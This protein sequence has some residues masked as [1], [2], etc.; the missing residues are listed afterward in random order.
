MTDEAAERFLPNAHQAQI[1]RS[2]TAGYLLRPRDTDDKAGY[3]LRF[4]FTA[5]MPKALKTALRHHA[6][7]N[8][9]E[10]IVDTPFGRKYI[11]VGRLETPD[12]RNPNIVAIWQIDSGT[13]L[14]RFVTAYRNRRAS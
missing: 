5:D 9:V 8:P 2:K 10:R 13:S 7:A 4:G 6:R 12:G 3:F 1:A 14:P 11:V